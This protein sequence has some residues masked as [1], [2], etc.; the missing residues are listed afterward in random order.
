MHLS[1]SNFERKIPDA[2]WRL[3]LPAAFIGFI[4]ILVS[5][6]VF[7]RCKGYAPTL[8]DEKF[9]WSKIRSSIKPDDTVVIG[10]SRG[11][12]DTDLDELAT[13][14]QIPEV[15]QLAMTGSSP[16][17]ILENLA[18]DETFKGTIICDVVPGLFF[19]PAGPPINKPT[20]WLNCYK[21]FSPSERVGLEINHFLESHL[22]YLKQDD[23]TLKELLKQVDLPNR[24][25]TIVYPKLPPFFL[26]MDGRREGKMT[27]RVLEDKA[28]RELIQNRWPPLFTPP[29]FPDNPTPEVIGQRIEGMMVS[30]INAVKA[31]VEKLHKRGAK[32]IFVRFPSSGP[33]LELESKLSPKAMVWGRLIAETGVPGIYW[34]DYDALKDF[35]CPE[36]SHLSAEDS[37]KFTKE[38]GPIL[39]EKLAIKK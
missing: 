12:F 7:W 37:V 6:E 2:N 35:D 8:N 16:T 20:E 30:K 4:I 21:S 36:W 15:K 3:I 29:P 25:A 39:K 13:A 19:A 32:I 22:A 23:L 18:N 24:T 27:N 34:Q 17:P 28:F 38:L 31:C 14:L 33:L 11:L 5:W 10:S 9:L 1:T 26:M